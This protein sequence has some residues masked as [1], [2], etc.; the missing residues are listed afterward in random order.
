MVKYSWQG[1]TGSN[2]HCVLLGIKGTLTI[3]KNLKKTQI[4]PSSLNKQTRSLRQVLFRRSYAIVP[5]NQ[6]Y[7][8]QFLDQI[9]QASAI[10][11]VQGRSLE[12]SLNLAEKKT[13]VTFANRRPGPKQKIE[14]TI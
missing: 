11:F 6:W 9:Y 3:E 2:T 4:R 7:I 14:A 12:T 8:S 10:I 13:C 5:M 1:N